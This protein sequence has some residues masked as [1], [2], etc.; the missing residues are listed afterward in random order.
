[1]QNAPYKLSAVKQALRIFFDIGL[2]PNYCFI[3]KIKFLYK[4]LHSKKTGPGPVSHLKKVQLGLGL[5]FKSLAHAG[6][7][8]AFFN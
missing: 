1:L 4:F 2:G 8:S 5:N 3:T 6:I 7:F